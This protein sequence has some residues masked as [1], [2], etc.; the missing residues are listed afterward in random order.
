[1][2]FLLNVLEKREELRMK[3]MSDLGRLMDD[4]RYARLSLKRSALYLSL[5][6]RKEADLAMRNFVNVAVNSDALFVRKGKRELGKVRYR[7]TTEALAVS[8]QINYKYAW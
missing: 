1:M 7:H 4:L 8:G 5:F 3:R 2:L 6:F